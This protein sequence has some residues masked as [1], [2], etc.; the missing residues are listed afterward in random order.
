VEFSFY[1]FL[2]IA[3]GYGFFKLSTLGLRPVFSLLMNKPAIRLLI[4]KKGPLRFLVIFS[5]LAVVAAYFYVK[6]ANHFWTGLSLLV[7][8]TLAKLGVLYKSRFIEVYYVIQYFRSIYPGLGF[9]LI[10][11]TYCYLAAGKKVTFW[12]RWAGAFSHIMIAPVLT[13]WL[14]YMVLGRLFQNFSDLD[15]VLL[16][17]NVFWSMFYLLYSFLLM[18]FGLKKNKVP[19]WLSGVL[20]VCAVILSGRYFLIA[21]IVMMGIGISD[22]WMRYKIFH[23]GLDEGK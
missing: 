15:A 2:L 19:A 17:L 14:I 23:R 12:I 13:G 22:I 1:L 21:L 10:A 5:I 3:A 4:N 6:Q 16:N 7:E 9:F 18:V 8:D 20:I 11:I